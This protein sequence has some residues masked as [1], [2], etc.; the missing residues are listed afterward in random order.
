MACLPD[1]Q[2]GDGALGMAVLGDDDTAVQPLPHAVPGG[3]GHGPGRLANRY[4]H[5]PTGREGAALQGPAHRLVRLDSG[6]GLT[7]DLFAVLSECHGVVSFAVRWTRRA[8]G[9]RAG[10]QRPWCGG[11]PLLLPPPGW[12][13]WANRA[14]PHLSPGASPYPWRPRGSWPDPWLGGRG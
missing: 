8:G 7:D 6:D 2:G 5:Q 3:L 12:A 13:V 14:R 1:A 10:Q 11:N 9:L 4:Q